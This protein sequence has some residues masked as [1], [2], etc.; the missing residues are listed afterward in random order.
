MELKPTGLE[1]V[2]AKGC[3][4]KIVAGM[5]GGKNDDVAVEKLT[6]GHPGID[7]LIKSRC[8][9]IDCKSVPRPLLFVG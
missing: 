1:T 9:V 2:T 8:L 5:H 4:E 6:A 7:P 3:V